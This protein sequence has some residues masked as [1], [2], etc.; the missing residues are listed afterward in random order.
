MVLFQLEDKVKYCMVVVME[1]MEVQPQTLIVEKIIKEP[2]EVE[3]LMVLWV[4][5]LVVLIVLVE[6]VEMV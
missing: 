3:V 5:V 6:M 4:E 1:Q 2:V